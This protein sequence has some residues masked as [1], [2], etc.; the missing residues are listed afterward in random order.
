MRCPACA[1][2]LPDEDLFCEEC[3]AALNPAPAPGPACACGAPASEVDEEG[4]CLRCGRRARRALP[5]DHIEVALSPFFAAVSDRGLRHDRNEDRFTIAQEGGGYALVVCDGVSSSRESELASSAVAE[6]VLDSL[7]K[8][9]RSGPDPDHGGRRIGDPVLVMRQA[10]AAGAERL[11]TATAPGSAD[12]T[13]SFPANRADPRAENPPSTTVVAALVADGLAT[14]GWA[15]DSRA[16]WIDEAGA[17]PLTEDHSW[18]NAVVATGEMTAE[19][20]SAA[21]QAHAITRW[22]GADA[23]DNATPDVIQHPAAHG[24]LL[25]CTDG[26]WN[27]APTPEAMARLVQSSSTPGPD[28]TGEHAVAI[29]RRLIEFANSQGGHDNITVALLTTGLAAGP[30]E[31]TGTAEP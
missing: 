11:A 3:G 27:Y 19:Q 10:I 16:Y 29:G 7:V 9:L 15:G 22:I 28:T 1:A 6:G 14:I 2:D 30:V 20:A 24:M 8:A 12:Q 21:P 17:R 26:L 31:P 4:Y 25:L 18:Q 13:A 5:A 23:G